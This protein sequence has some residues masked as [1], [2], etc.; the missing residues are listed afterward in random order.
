MRVAARAPE[1]RRAA[2]RAR[3]GLDSRGEIID[4]DKIKEQLFAGGTPHFAYVD[5]LRLQLSTSFANGRRRA[6]PT[7]VDEGLRPG[8]IHS[9]RIYRV[10]PPRGLLSVS[11]KRPSR[12][13]WLECVHF[14]EKPAF[15]ATEVYTPVKK[16]QGFVKER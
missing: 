4:Y 3:R 15:L 9:S 10:L 6:S 12:A 5:E 8:E 14:G 2:L 1:S 16:S 13:D 7:A 11:P